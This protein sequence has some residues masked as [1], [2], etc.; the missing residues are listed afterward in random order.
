MQTLDAKRPD[1]GSDDAVLRH[2]RAGD[3]ALFEVLVRRH[4]Q[5]LFR[6]ARA[7][8]GNDA[9]AE[10][11]MQEAYVR[12]FASLGGFRGEALFS[13]WLTRICVNEALG[14]LRKTKRVE[15]FENDERNE[16]AMAR[17]QASPEQDAT[18]AELAAWL[19]RALDALPDQFRVVF[20]LRAIE[21]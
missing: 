15:S 5:R 17:E 7:I 10:D 21:G 9:E 8:L 11:A 1:L 3:T 13:T 12:A 19:Q 16:T 14:R 18:S 6:T 20:V 4:N 2:V